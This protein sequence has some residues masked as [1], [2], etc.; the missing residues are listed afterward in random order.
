[1]WPSVFGIFHLVNALK[2]YPRSL[3]QSFIPFYGGMILRSVDV[4]HLFIL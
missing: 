2:V 3:Y 1:M 4:L